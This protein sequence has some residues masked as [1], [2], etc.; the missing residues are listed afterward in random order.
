MICSF[1]FARSQYDKEAPL[2]RQ[3]VQRFFLHS[4]VLLGLLADLPFKDRLSWTCEHKSIR[5]R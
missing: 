5:S 2:S 3:V 4:P 1:S